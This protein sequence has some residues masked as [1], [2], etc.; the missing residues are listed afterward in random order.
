MD[1]ISHKFLNILFRLLRPFVRLLIENGVSYRTF[2][3]LT[4]RAYVQ[5][6]TKH[7]GIRGRPTNISRVAVMTGLTRKEVKR[8][9]ELIDQGTE[10]ALSELEKTQSPAQA[11]MLGWQTDSDFLDERGKPLALD[12]YAEGSKGP[13]TFSDLVARYAGDIPAGALRHELKRTS[14]VTE[15]KETKLIPN[16]PLKLATDEEAQFDEELMTRLLA[17]T[18]ASMD[19]R[20]AG[21]LRTADKSSDL[22]DGIAFH[23][24]SSSFYI[25]REQLPGVMRALRGLDTKFRESSSE[26]YSVPKSRLLSGDDKKNEP[27]S[28]RTGWYM[29]T[30]DSKP[31]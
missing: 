16:S 7:Y 1:N 29:L 12:V 31:Q 3:E 8:I 22:S 4:K 20:L 11:V 2:A 17:I 6:A 15:T 18:K 27:L 9:R 25:E 23:S 10:A 5:Q 28:V 26:P 21:N 14:T 13:V 30:D 24:E 19:N